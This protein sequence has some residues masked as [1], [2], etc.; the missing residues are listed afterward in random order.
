[1]YRILNIVAVFIQGTTIFMWILFPESSEK[2]IWLLPIALILI[3]F[4][5]WHNYVDFDSKFRKFGS[6]D[7]YA[8]ILNLCDSR[9]HL[10]YLGFVR[11][12][13]KFKPELLENGYFTYTFI[14]I[15]KM[16]VFL[17]IM[18]LSVE[19][20]G[21]QDVGNLFSMFTDAF[22]FSVNGTGTSNPSY[23]GLD[24]NQLNIW[25][26]RLTKSNLGDWLSNG[27]ISN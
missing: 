27:P 18:L 13:A 9:I 14:S 7:A 19:I 16:L 2:N 17:G 20:Q 24:K 21:V 23:A 10:G 11:Y 6:L 1:V 12:L 8:D 15:W 22:G 25:L 3:S 4:G 5:F 26:V